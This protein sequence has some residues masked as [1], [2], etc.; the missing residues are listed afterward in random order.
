MLA[1]TDLQLAQNR[2]DAVIGLFERAE[3]SPVPAL[4]SLAYD[5]VAGVQSLGALRVGGLISAGGE[6]PLAPRLYEEFVRPYETN[7]TIDRAI[8][9]MSERLAALDTVL[10]DRGT[11]TRT[12]AHSLAEVGAA[13]EAVTPTLALMRDWVSRLGAANDVARQ[14]NA[15]LV[16]ELAAAAEQ[17]VTVR[18]E[19]ARSSRDALIDPV[20]LLA[21]RA[22]MDTSFATAMEAARND[23]RTD[24]ALAVVDIDH[25]KTFNDT[26]GHQTGDQVLRLVGR[27]LGASVRPGDVCG[28]MGGDEFVV[29]LRDAATGTGSVASETIRRAVRDGDL[30]KLLGRGVLGGITAS[31]GVA[32][33]RDG[34]SIASF[35]ERADRCL[36]EAKRQGR[37]RVVS[38]APP[39]EF[40]ETDDGR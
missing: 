38:D 1:L 30:S 11:L 7:E 21:N 8:A 17:V 31:I 12:E 14:A 29:L 4:Y 25:F 34:D 35:L 27:A 36:L 24:L 6:T 2:G 10:V 3:V 9:T 33:Y 16:K 22:G 15:L 23:G 13:L 18:D 5:Y 20:T 28:R 19:I 32:H 26:Y 39:P 40:G 37:N